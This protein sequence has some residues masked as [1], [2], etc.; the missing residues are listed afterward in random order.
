MIDSSKCGI[1][2]LRTVV[3]NFVLLM[4][5]MI[6]A[7]TKIQTSKN[8]KVCFRNQLQNITYLSQ[9]AQKFLQDRTV[10]FFSDKT[11]E[12][13]KRL[14][15]CLTKHHAMNAYSMSRSIAPRILDLGTRWPRPLYAQGNS[16]WYPLYRRLGG[17]QSRSGRGS[18]EKNS[19]LPPVIEP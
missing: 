1:S 7:K 15:L 13:F 8:N 6:N 14:V 11:K 16:P 19:H 17:P 4:P 10:F 2:C 5:V 3:S 12:K 18:E 9:S